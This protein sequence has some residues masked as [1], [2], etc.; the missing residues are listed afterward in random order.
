MSVVKVEKKGNIAWLILNKPEVLNVLDYEMALALS[1]AVETLKN[2]QQ[3][4][5]II[6]TGAGQHFMGGG[7]IAYFKK[8]TEDFAKQGEQ[9]FPNDLFDLLHNA[10][11]SLR[12]M[13]KIVIGSVQGAV[14][15]FGLSLLLSCDLAIAADNGIFSVAYCKIGT[16]PD[17]GMSY[18]L[19]R[20]V[21][22]KKAMELAL[23]GSRFSSDEAKN[24]GIV[25]ALVCVDE[26]ETATLELANNLC[27][28]PRDV[29]VRTKSLLN[30]SYDKRLNE[31]LDDE[32]LNFQQCMREKDFS[33]GVTAFCEKRKPNFN[34]P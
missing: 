23:T 8:L 21:G 18:F 33:E 1:H 29:L 19:P 16:T 20:V 28:G 7:D 3:I 4:A 14:A 5:C 9:V 26:L 6:L 22:A 11:F 10:I 24:W 2:D 34:K 13:D 30:Q 17:G 25:N 32:A 15:G 12:T 31:Q 27:K